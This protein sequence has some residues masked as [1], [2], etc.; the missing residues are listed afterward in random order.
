MNGAGEGLPLASATV[1]ET[2]VHGVQ[3]YRLPVFHDHR[4]KLTVGEFGDFLPFLP[5]RYFVT[6]QVPGANVRGEHAHRECVQ[7]LTCVRGACTVSVDDGKNRREFRL[8]DPRLGVLVPPGIW[9]AEF[10]HTGDSV[11]VVFASH[12]YDPGDYMRDYDVFK[13]GALR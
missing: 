13:A 4:G 6:Y 7:F 12:H 9:A 2:G 1:E 5:L 8:D 11:L 3:L 10:D